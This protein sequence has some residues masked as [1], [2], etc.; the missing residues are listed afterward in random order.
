MVNGMIDPSETLARVYAFILGWLDSSEKVT[1]SSENLGED[2]EPA[3]GTL[4]Q[5]ERNE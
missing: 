1:A 5:V 3:D 4:T 2:E